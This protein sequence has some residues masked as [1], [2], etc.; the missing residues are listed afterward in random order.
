MASESGDEVGALDFMSS[1]FDLF[2]ALY[3]KHVRLTIPK[4]SF[5]DYI[6]KYRS[7]LKR[8]ANKHS[9]KVCY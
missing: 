2:I 5:L 9:A 8:R 6:H 1:K 7:V 3:S 4:E